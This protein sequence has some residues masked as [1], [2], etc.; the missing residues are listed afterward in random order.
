MS[1]NS[2]KKEDNNRNNKLLSNNKLE[3][4]IKNE[5]S[6]SEMQILDNTS[7]NT[8]SDILIFNSIDNILYAIYSGDKSLICFNI[9]DN[10]KIN[11]IKNAFNYADIFFKYH[12]DKKN[13]KDLILTLSCFEL[14]I[15]LWK[16]NDLECLLNIKKIYENGFLNSACFLNE[17]NKMYIITSNYNL[18]YNSEP[19]KVYDLNGNKIGEI[20]DSKKDGIFYIESYYDNKLSKNYIITCNKG[21]IKSYDF[22]ENKEYRRYNDN[23][24]DFKRNEQIIIYNNKETT[25]LIVSNSDGTIMIWNFHSGSLLTRIKVNN[26]KLFG[27]LLINEK[28]IFIG[29]EDGWIKSV[30]IENEFVKNLIL[31]KKE[32]ITIKKI[33]HPKYG[34]CFLSQTREKNN[35]NIMFWKI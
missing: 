6:D 3:N 22:N 28:N 12:L 25:K 2:D 18:G 29:C 9:I 8:F 7:I 33:I 5:N 13:K 16:I 19:I 30:D 35:N 17:N 14:N 20:N 27:I 1:N 11:E 10:K 34:Q 15:K 21:F 23:D 31:F 32:V 4:K 26:C 24:E